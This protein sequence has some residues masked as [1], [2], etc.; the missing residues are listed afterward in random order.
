MLVTEPTREMLEQFVKEIRI[1]DT[2]K[3]EIIWNSRG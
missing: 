3:I 1:R 2:D